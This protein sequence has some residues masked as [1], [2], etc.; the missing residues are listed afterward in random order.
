MKIEN[1]L[2]RKI[3]LANIEALEEN[4]IVQAVFLS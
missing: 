4:F 3:R 2:A 1:L